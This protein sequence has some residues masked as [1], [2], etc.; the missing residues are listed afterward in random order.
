MLQKGH[1]GEAPC[2]DRKTEIRK[3]ILSNRLT[4]Q[5]Y[6][7]FKTNMKIVKKRYH[8][9]L[10]AN[11]DLTESITQMAEDNSSLKGLAFMLMIMLLFFQHELSRGGVIFS[12]GVMIFVI[13]F[14]IWMNAR[15]RNLPFMAELRLM[16]LAWRLRAF[17][18][19]L[20][21]KRKTTYKAEKWRWRIR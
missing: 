4:P 2:M 16:K 13:A 17:L 19:A 15:N 12:I 14:S 9:D 10:T 3:K 11:F 5:D 20:A 8:P 21:S 18:K 1:P 6:S 7:G